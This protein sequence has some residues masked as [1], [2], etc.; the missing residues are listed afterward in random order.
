MIT[1]VVTIQSTQ[2]SIRSKWSLKWSLSGVSDHWN[3]HYL[4]KWTLAWSLSGERE[5]VMSINMVSFR[6]KWSLHGHGERK[7][8]ISI[9]LVTICFF[10]CLGSFLANQNWFPIMDYIHIYCL[11]YIYT[12]YHCCGLRS[13]FQSRE[14]RKK[15]VDVLKVDQL[16]L[17]NSTKGITNF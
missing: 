9:N 11:Y 17:F 14:K 4:D 8:V 6:R 3:R 15:K 13:N 10:V 16:A 7:K 2:S 12:V 5:K 1:N